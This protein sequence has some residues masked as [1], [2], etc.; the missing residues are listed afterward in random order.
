MILNGQMGK[1]GPPMDGK[2]LHVGDFGCGVFPASAPLAHLDDD[3]RRAGDGLRAARRGPRRRLVHRRGRHLA[4]R[5]A[6][7]DQPLRRA[8]AAGDL[9]RAEQPD[10]AVD[11]RAPSSPPSACSP[12]RR[13]GTASRASRSTG[14]TRT[15]SRRRSRGRPSG[16]ARVGSDAD[17]AVRDAHV[18]PRAPRRHALP[19]PAT[20]TRRGT[21]RADGAGYADRGGLRLLGEARSDRDLRGAARRRAR[22]RQ[23]RPRELEGGGRG[24]RSRPRRAR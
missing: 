23:A 1:A 14:P 11:A 16:R 18:R 21:T 15:R 19:R 9:L 4:R 8:Q 24:A 13:R 6:R 2:D 17:R 22:H 20:R 10:R 5:V 7:G 3:G 12:T